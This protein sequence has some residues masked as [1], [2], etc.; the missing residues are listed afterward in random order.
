MTPC[1]SGADSSHSWSGCGAILLLEARWR[2]ANALCA[3]LLWH[4]QRTE[5]RVFVNRGRLTGQPVEDLESNPLPE[6]AVEEIHG[7]PLTDH[8]TNFFQAVADRK[9]TI[10]DPCSHHRALSVCH[11]A[12]IAARL[13]RSLKWDPDT[14]RIVEDEQAQGF[15]SRAKRQGFEIEM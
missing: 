4:A 2:R 11:L 10:S 3:E 6:G 1:P 8:V 9:P 13:G 5:G 7:R 12:G 14:Q 15:V